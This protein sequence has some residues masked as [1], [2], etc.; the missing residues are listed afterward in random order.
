MGW[1][2]GFLDY[3]N[4]GWL[5]IIVG[6][7]HVYPQLD[8]AKLGASAPYRQRRLLYHNR[9]DGTFDE[10][11]ARYGPALNE[12]RVSRGLTLGDLDNDGRM[13]VVIADLDGYPL[14]LRNVLADAGTGSW[15]SSGA[16]RRT[17]AR[18]GRW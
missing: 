1:G 9:G 11:A 13:D 5:D 7:G 17:R 6:N 4:D 3:D 10:V 12:P 2:P 15:S 8:Q 14:V 16:S 18:W